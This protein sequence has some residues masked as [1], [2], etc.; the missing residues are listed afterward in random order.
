[1]PATVLLYPDAVAVVNPYLRAALAAAGQAVP[2]VSRVPSD[3]PDKFVRVQR[4][5]GPETFPGVMDGAQVTVD[6]WAADDGAAMDLAQLAR[7]LIHD[8]PGTVQSGV[9]VHRV[10]EFGG[11][12]DLPDPV[13]NAPR[14]TFTVQIQMRG[15]PAA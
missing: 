13:S 11:P 5:G 2:V 9:S 3:R 6:C 1:M 7:K 10:V 8:M 15:K 4:T 12:N 14:V